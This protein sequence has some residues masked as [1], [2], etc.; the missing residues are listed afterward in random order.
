[1]FCAT[2]NSTPS[3]YRYWIRRRLHSCIR[4]DRRSAGKY[5]AGQGFVEITIKDLEQMLHVEVSKM[6]SKGLITVYTGSKA[7]YDHVSNTV[8]KFGK[9]LRLGDD[10]LRPL[11]EEGHKIHGL[12]RWTVVEINEIQPLAA[13]EVVIGEEYGIYLQNKIVPY[14][15]VGIDLR[16]DTFVFA[17]SIDPTKELPVHVDSW[18]TVYSASVDTHGESLAVVVECKIRSRSGHYI[19]QS[20]PIDQIGKQKF[21]MDVGQ[22]HVIEAIG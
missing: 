9:H 2:T 16:T 17:L 3:L 10:I 19:R 8:S 1:M 20:L 14:T 18:P 4:R 15:L 11:D 7:S 21:T 13:K 12:Q 6:W 5:S 22:S